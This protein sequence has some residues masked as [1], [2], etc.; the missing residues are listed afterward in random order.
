MISLRR[1]KHA[2]FIFIY[3]RCL[4]LDL[5]VDTQDKLPGK[6]VQLYL[7]FRLLYQLC[8]VIILHERRQT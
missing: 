6:V 2:D 3:I 7:L 1:A 5:N 4:G 8:K